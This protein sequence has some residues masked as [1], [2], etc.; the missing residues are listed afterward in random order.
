M[1]GLRFNISALF[2]ISAS[3]ISIH[4]PAPPEIA[5]GDGRRRDTDNILSAFCSAIFP[6]FS[7]FRQRRRFP[8]KSRNRPRRLR[9]RGRFLRFYN[10]TFTFIFI[11]PF[12]KKN[13]RKK[14]PVFAEMQTWPLL[15]RLFYYSAVKTP[16]LPPSFLTRRISVICMPLSIALHMS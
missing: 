6:A 4:P 1:V 13:L 10:Y 7:D 11:Q 5:G 15:N 9:W 14:R 12:P 2:I 8:R 3:C 16:D